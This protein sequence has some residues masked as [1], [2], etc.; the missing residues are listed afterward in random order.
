MTKT[1]HTP[2]AKPINDGFCINGKALYDLAKKHGKIKAL[3]PAVDGCEIITYPTAL[4]FINATPDNIHNS[5][6]AKI[7][8][9]LVGVLGFTPDELQRVSFA[10]I[11]S[12][13]KDGEI[14]HSDMAAVDRILTLAAAQKTVAELEQATA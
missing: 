8:A 1:T 2:A 11:F 10:D 12:I 13:V 5:S 9:F 6:I 4:G 7:Y 14:Y 3:L